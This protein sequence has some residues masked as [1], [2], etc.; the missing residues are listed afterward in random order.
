[1]TT[2]HEQI[3]DLLAADLQEQLSASERSEL[4]AHLVE[5][6]DCRRLHKEHQLMN[7]ILSNTFEE[8][9]PDLKFEQRMLGA[10]RQRVPDRGPGVMRFLLLAMRSRATQIAAAA[11]LLLALVQTGRMITGEGAFRPTS[12][13]NE[14]PASAVARG[15]ADSES[16]FRDKQDTASAPAQNIAGL[17]KSADMKSRAATDQISPMKAPRADA[18]A[19]PPPV[20]QLKDGAGTAAAATVPNG[21]TESPALEAMQ[22]EPQAAPQITDTRKLIRNGSVELEVLSFEET[23]QKITGFAAQDR[24]YV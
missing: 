1:M 22:M 16:G 23:V 12:T 11:A 20:S 9:K 17:R 8:G 14:A 7:T 5:C 21:R 2:I 6:A 15:G 19:P 24:G 18:A 4:H 10:F 3:D 13:F